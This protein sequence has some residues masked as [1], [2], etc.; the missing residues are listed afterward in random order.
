VSFGGREWARFAF[1]APIAKARHLAGYLTHPPADPDSNKFEYVLNL[2]ASPSAAQLP[3]LDPAKPDPW[4][5]STL[6]K[7]ARV[8]MRDQA[9]EEVQL[10]Y[11]GTFGGHHVFQSS[12]SLDLD[13]KGSRVRM[14]AGIDGAAHFARRPSDGRVEYHF[15]VAPDEERHVVST[16]P[17]TGDAAPA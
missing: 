17:T 9:G 4:T 8:R 13:D 2:G 12:E 15:P 14:L 7:G 16:A 10:E 6:T 11:T 3:L 5:P 1:D